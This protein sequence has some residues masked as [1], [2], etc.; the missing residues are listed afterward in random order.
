MDAAFWQRVLA[1]AQA[2]AA[3]VAERQRQDFRHVQAHLKSDG[4]LVTQTD[5]WSDRQLRSALSS[6]FP[7]HGLLSEETSHIF[8]KTDWCWVIDPLDGTTNFARGIPLWGISLGLLYRGKPVFGYV[9]I[10][11]LQQKFHGYW[12]GDSGLHCPI[13][14]YC[15]GQAIQVCDEALSP[16]HLFS[17][18]T[19]SISALQSPDQPKHPF[20][21]KIRMLGVATYNLLTVALGSTLGGTEATPKIWDIAAT[22]PILQ[23]AGAHWQSLCD[24]A[25]FPLRPGENYQARNFPVLVA[26]TPAIA[27]HFIPFVQA[28]VPRPD[29]PKPQN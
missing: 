29:I 7:D 16:S 12:P 1:V 18:C 3:P 15:D 9:E 25:D 27:R 6:A 21:C 26:A 13:G 28:S 24:E 8:P 2:A 4:S 11:P 14:A 23:A 10:P 20:P 5:E 17:F 22:W 19:R